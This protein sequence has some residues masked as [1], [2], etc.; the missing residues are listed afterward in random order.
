MPC[1][2]FSRSGKPRMAPNRELK[3]LI[4]LLDD[5]DERVAV[6]AMGELLY[7]ES[8]LGEALAELQESSN[9]LLRRRAH[10]LQAAITLRQRR[11][12]FLDLLYSPELRL[13]DGLIEVH[14]QWFDNDSRPALVK[15]WQR[16]RD[17]AA[18]KLIR[19]LEELAYF[20]RKYGLQ[21][22]P[23]STLAP[24][25]YCL[26]SVL[27]QKL[28]ATSVVAAIGLELG[29]ESGLA[30]QLVRVFGDF[31]LLD[32]AGRLLFP[33]RNYQL[34]SAPGQVNCEVWEIRRLLNYASLQLLSYAVNS[35]SFRYIQTI[36]QALSGADD[37]EPLDFLPYPY[38]P[39]EEEESRE[40]NTP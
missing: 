39:T 3:N 24:E 17:E 2:A 7:R 27:D 30:L 34:E 12:G 21:A 4:S 15:L 9:P 8:E 25:N 31:A 11:R 38:Y 5:P 29:A 40:E 23:E 35:D 19:S 22:V 13:I 16:F 26:G 1:A 18:G 28:G 10:Q 33:G 37:G 14:L 20:L 6:V 32:A 36:G